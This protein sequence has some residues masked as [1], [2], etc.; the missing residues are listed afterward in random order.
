MI[1]AVCNTTGSRGLSAAISLILP[2]CI[3]SISDSASLVACVTLCTAEVLSGMV[4]SITFDG[5]VD[6]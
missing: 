5:K 4:L 1:Q 6:L 2:P 3:V